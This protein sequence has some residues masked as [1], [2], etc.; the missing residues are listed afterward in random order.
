[1]LGKFY[2]HMRRRFGSSCLIVLNTHVE[3]MELLCYDIL[4]FAVPL[5]IF[6]HVS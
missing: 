4:S 3:I 1:M 2:G 6:E 5:S